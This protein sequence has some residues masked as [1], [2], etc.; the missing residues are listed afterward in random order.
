VVVSGGRLRSGQTDF[1]IGRG[2]ERKRLR[3]CKG[4]RVNSSGLA[5]S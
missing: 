1:F 2:Q 5:K 3:R 4:L